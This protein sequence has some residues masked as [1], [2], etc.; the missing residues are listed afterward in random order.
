MISYF[1]YPSKPVVVFITSKTSTTS[2]LKKESEDFCDFKALCL[3]SGLA[4]N[5]LVLIKTYK[6]L[7]RKPFF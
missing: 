6:M 3:S 7:S 2:F 5:C 4:S 1:E